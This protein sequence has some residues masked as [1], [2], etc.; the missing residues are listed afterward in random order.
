MNRFRL[1]CEN[2]VI[3]GFGGIIGKAVPLLM[4]PVVTR[5]MPDASYFGISDLSGTI[6]SFFMAVAGMGMYDA[7]YRYFFEKD[8]EGY[9][10]AVCS[11]ALFFTVAVSVAVF[12]L[13]VL[14]REKIADLFFQDIQYSYIVYISASAMLVGATNSIMAAPTRMQNKRRIYLATNLIGSI[15]GYVIALPLFFVGYYAVALPMGA[16]CSALI[17]EAI[18]WWLNRSWFDFRAADRKLLGPLLSLALPIMP[19][20]LIY[21]VFSSCDKLMITDLIGLGATGI[22][23]ASAKIGQVS[24]L[25]YVAFAGGWQ[26]FAFSTMKEGNQVEMNSKVFEYL[27][28]LS[29]SATMLLCTFSR[30]IFRIIFPEEYQAGYLVAPYLFLA[31]LLL[32]LYQVIGNQFLVIKKTW[33]SLLI[34][35]GGATVNVWANARL[36]P[37]LGIEGAAIATL[38]GYVVAVVAC[39]AVLLRMGLMVLPKRMVAASMLMAAYLLAW[40]F[41]FSDD[42]LLSGLVALA[43]IGVYMGLYRG[44]LRC[45]TFWIYTRER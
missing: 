39:A 8:E 30:L 9:R 40:R 11:T 13:M 31:P 19:N 26:Y 42:M 22:Y 44:E 29:F 33:P 32:M 21:W 5:L 23:S 20:F 10:R 45:I 35:C 28:I 37:G 34:L 27:G 38:A 36:I 15:V 12:V 25:I 24:Q 14:F 1:F 4:L 7:M 3:Y 43:A 6:T 41:L 16:A 17:L 18:F 2:F